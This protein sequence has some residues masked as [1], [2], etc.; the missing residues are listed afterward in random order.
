MKPWGMNNGDFLP[1]QQGPGL[2][3]DLRYASPNNF[4]GKSLYDPSTVPR[5]HRVAWEKLRIAAQFLSENHSD[6]CLLIFD[7]LRPR[8]VQKLLWEAVKGTD[9]ER[10]VANPERGSIHNYGM[11]VDLSICDL[12]GRELDMGT[13]FDAFTP[14][15]E[16]Q[17]EERLFEEGL[18]SREHIENRMILRNAMQEAGFIQLPH[19]WWHY[20][21][22]D[23]D[24]VRSKFTIVE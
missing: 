19:E 23:R 21:A 22:L 8:S 5:L 10:Y 9:H 13:A 1:L 7:A 17:L 18:L 24:E 12:E 2:R 14:L 6:Y 3:V 4:V 20:E 15:A 16:P 11:A